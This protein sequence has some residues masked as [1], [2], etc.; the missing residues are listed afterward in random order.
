M[1]YQ[2]GSTSCV[3][4]RRPRILGVL[5]GAV[6][7]LQVVNPAQ[8]QTVAPSQV[9]PREIAPLQMPAPTGPKEDVVPNFTAPV[10]GAGLAFDSGDGAIDGAFK[11]MATAN[12]AF[13]ARFC[14]QR[15]TVDSHLDSRLPLGGGVGRADWT[16][17]RRVGVHR[18]AFAI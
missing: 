5:A 17:G 4:A 9:T 16:G 13:I 6:T 1:L 14:G 18:C 10:E 2:S 12:A 15:L 7:A 8:A 11:D 3:V